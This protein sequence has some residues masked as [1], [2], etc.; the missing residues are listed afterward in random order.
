MNSNMLGEVGNELATVRTGHFGGSY[1]I[2]HFSYV[3]CNI[4]RLELSV[5]SARTSDR[6]GMN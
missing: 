6:R 1:A 2:M 3:L 4:M 5:A